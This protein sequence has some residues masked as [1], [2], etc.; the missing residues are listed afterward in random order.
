MNLDFTVRAIRQETTDVKSF[1]LSP[2]PGT[3]FN[4]KPGQFLTVIHPQRPD[5]RRSYSLS[6]HPVFDEPTIT[7]RRIANGEVSRWL[8]DDVKPGDILHTAGVSGRFTLP[9]KSDEFEPIVFLCAGTGITPAMSLIKEALKVRNSKKVILV[10]SNRSPVTTVFLD[11]IRLLEKEHKDHF[12]VEYFN[13]NN[14]SLSRA[15]LGRLALEALLEQY[16]ARPDKGLFFLCGPHFYMDNIL[17]TLLTAGVP[18]E[19][20]RREIFFNPE[21]LPKPDPPDRLPHKV[22]IEYRGQQHILTVQYP[23]SILQTAK[24]AGLILPYSCEAG[25]CG[26]CAATCTKGEIWMLRN[27]VLLDNE[28]SAGRVLTCTGYPVGGDA[29]LVITEVG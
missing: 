19:N 8:F 26:T 24:R 11:K 22:T 10:Y 12:I 17:I 18:D 27:E 3:T 20:I 21:P 1:I 15:R 14:Q 6:S 28:I 16:V 29:E 2:P 23:D 4:Y 25:R 13:S 7:L 5:Q 9:E